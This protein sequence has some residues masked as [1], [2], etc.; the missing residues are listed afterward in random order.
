MW[1]SGIDDIVWSFVEPYCLT[2]AIWCLRIC[3][4]D[5]TL[6]HDDQFNDF[7]SLLYTNRLLLKPVFSVIST[8]IDNKEVNIKIFDVELAHS[9]YSIILSMLH[10]LEVFWST[11]AKLIWLNLPGHKSVSFSIIE[12]LFDPIIHFISSLSWHEI[13]FMFTRKATRTL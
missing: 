12:K 7:L 2:R 3:F 5:T 1:S 11:Y 10:I 4:K 6:S 9:V 13:C 8:L